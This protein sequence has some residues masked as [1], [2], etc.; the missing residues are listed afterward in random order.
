MNPYFD[1]LT[2]TNQMADM[3]CDF[4][5]ITKLAPDPTNI[6]NIQ[7]DN[8]SSIFIVP[9]DNPLDKYVKSVSNEIDDT[10]K[11]VVSFDDTIESQKDVDNFCNRDSEISEQ[12]INGI[13]L[14][15]T[16]DN[17]PP[18]NE[19]NNKSIVDS[20][21]EITP[22]SYVTRNRYPIQQEISHNSPVSCVDKLHVDIATG[23]TEIE[24]LTTPNVPED[25]LLFKQQPKV[26]SNRK[27][28][29]NLESA[30]V[31][32]NHE[33]NDDVISESDTN[34][35][36]INDIAKTS[37]DN[38]LDNND[39]HID[40]ID[41]KD[42]GSS[43]NSDCE[44]QSDQTSNLIPS[45]NVTC[46][47]TQ[48]DECRLANGITKNHT[49]LHESNTDAIDVTLNSITHPNKSNNSEELNGV[50]EKCLSEDSFDA[51]VDCS[52]NANHDTS[53][54]VNITYSTSNASSYVS[55]DQLS[56]N[57]T[58]YDSMATD[59]TSIV[60]DSMNPSND[61]D[62]DT[63]NDVS[64]SQSANSTTCTSSQMTSEDYTASSRESTNDATTSAS[65]EIDNTCNTEDDGDSQLL[66]ELSAEL[67]PQSTS[68]IVDE[69][70]DFREMYD[71]T[72]NMLNVTANKF[73]RFWIFLVFF[74][75][76]LFIIIIFSLFFNY[77]IFFLIF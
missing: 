3:N 68:S 71:Q 41:E 72:R 59:C 48:K 51:S 61:N 22:V 56:E 57:T 73:T 18:V 35:N 58:T 64:L 14:Q 28:S 30:N 9:P 12:I 38:S 16:F 27:Q 74:S 15:E 49:S 25:L 44:L 36:L 26:I 1:K 42:E 67:S 20:S 2:F 37:S 75:L 55:T 77:F 13:T 53:N 10:T 7:V 46:N 40:V 45:S 34:I 17:Q 60:T 23:G 50:T 62:E 43:R 6:K 70:P 69:K 65:T 52:I 76:N 63:D 24:N 33:I 11:N 19:S 54:S 4:M 32:I 66:D 31:E 39:V 47:Q 8:D 21:D 5:E 29:D